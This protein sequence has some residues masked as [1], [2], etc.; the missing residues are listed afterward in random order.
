[1]RT[2]L[3]LLSWLAILL[4]ICAQDY[5]TNVKRAMELLG[6]DSIDNAET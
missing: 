5:Q 6:N 4:P 1:M 3:L 2:F